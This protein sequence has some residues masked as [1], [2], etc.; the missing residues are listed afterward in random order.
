MLSFFAPSERELA[1]FFERNRSVPAYASE[2][3]AFETPPVGFFPLHYAE[4]VGQ[5]DVVFE[6]GRAVLNDWLHFPTAWTRPIVDGPTEAGQQVAVVSRCF[7]LYVTNLCRVQAVEET[8]DGPIASFSIIYATV[9]GHDMVGAER[10]RLTWNRQSDD[11]EYSITSYARPSSFLARV[12]WWH[13]RRLQQRFVHDSA[14][15]VRRRIDRQM[16][17]LSEVSEVSR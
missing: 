9:P 15:I 6:V 13:I 7:S 3:D 10:F 11:V 17:T 12:S 4:T 16:A 5:G 14:A 2:P 8:L 1:T